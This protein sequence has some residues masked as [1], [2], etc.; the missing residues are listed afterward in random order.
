M[1]MND[2]ENITKNLSELEQ[3]LT[4]LDAKRDIVIKKINELRK[5][6]SLIP[7]SELSE[8]NRIAIFMS[9]FKGRNDV[10][11]KRFQS[12]K[13]GRSGYQP[14]CSNEWIPGICQ[15]PKIKCADCRCRKL[16]PVTELVVRAHLLGHDERGNDFTIGVYP[17]LDDETCWFLAVDFDKKDWSEDVSAFIETCD[18][19]NVPASVERS[20]SGNGAHVWIFFSEPV[21]AS[22]ARQMGG[23]ILT[24]TM[25]ARPE[26]GFDSYDRFFPNQDTLPKGGFG[27]LIALPLQGKPRK[28]GNSVFLDKQLIPYTN[29]WEYLARVKKM[30]ALEVQ[31]IAD[32]AIKN[33][34]VT[35]VNAVDDRDDTL[36][37]ELPPS[38]KRKEKALNITLSTPLDIVID[39]Q[40]YFR[41]DQIIPPLKSRLL[42]IAAFQNP[43]FYKTQAMRMPVYNKPRIIS[44]SEDFPEHIGLP[45]GC[46]DNIASLLMELKLPYR[47]TDKRMSGIV[48]DVSFTGKLREEQQQAVSALLPYDIGV[49]SASTAFGKTVVGAYMIAQRKVNTLILVHRVQLIEQWKARLMSFL[50]IPSNQ[51]GVI[52]GGK[53]KPGGIIDISTIQSLC[54]NNVVDDLLAD[55]G[56]IIVDECHHLSAFSFELVARQCKARFF[57]GLSATLTRKDGHHPIIFMQCGPIRYRVND[58]KQAEARPFH[59]RVVVRKTSTSLPEL[60]AGDQMPI[61]QVYDMLMNNI[62]RNDLIENDVLKAISAKRNPVVITERKAHLE[63]LIERFQDKVQNLIVLKGGM[64]KKEY[65]MMM[66]RL[67]R[68][69]INAERLILATGRFLGEGFDDARLDTLFLTLPISWKGTLA[70]YAGRLHRLHYSKK[71]VLI[72]DYVDSEIPVTSRMFQRRCSGYKAIGYEMDFCEMHQDFLL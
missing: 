70:Q 62:E 15:K 12:K 3:E 71:E 31:N 63:C 41:K 37:W 53:H 26:L 20:R 36:P 59:H 4:A 27:N 7:R 47:V 54:R 11:P 25:D 43:E 50:D 13:T 1:K 21:A 5:R 56:H 17:L 48:S 64:R 38:R 32:E 23:F 29:Q 6:H 30:T 39:N 49:L 67:E 66:E 55:Y 35:G 69:P 18:K 44:C 68:I 61:H 42:R 10:Y 28:N 33:N 57:L 46:A 16:L 2:A 19:L 58:R 24:E 14:A 9:L 72:F 65:R 52:G 51:I 22:K 40:I 8:H 60:P 34:R 45:R